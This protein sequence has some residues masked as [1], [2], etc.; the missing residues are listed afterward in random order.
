[1]GLKG[2][3]VLC[4]LGRPYYL[5]ELAPVG[6]NL[7]YVFSCIPPSDFIVLSNVINLFLCL[8]VGPEG[9]IL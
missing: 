1:M 5:G 6:Y 2:I 9:R 3:P 8:V 7:L 4:T